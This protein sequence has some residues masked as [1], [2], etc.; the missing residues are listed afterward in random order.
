MAGG[1][2]GSQAGMFFTFIGETSKEVIANRGNI[3]GIDW[4]DVV[5]STAADWLDGFSVDLSEWYIPT[6]RTKPVYW[7]EIY[8]TH[9]EN[10]VRAENGLPLREFYGIIND[11][12]TA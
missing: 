9:I 6:G 8:S 7:A 10:L 2:V 12:D 5:V 3:G 1:G 11:L 4:N